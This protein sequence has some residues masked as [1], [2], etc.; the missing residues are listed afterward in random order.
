MNLLRTLSADQ[1]VDALVDG[2]KDNNT[3]AEIAA[4]KAQQDQMVATM[5]GFGEVKEKDVVSLDYANGSTTILLNG[6]ANGFDQHVI[7]EGLFDEVDGSVL[8]RLNR[9]LHVA[10]T[11][12]DD[13]RKHRLARPQLPQQLD[14][15]NVRHPQIGDQAAVADVRGHLEKGC[16]RCMR[17]DGESRGSE[18][19]RK[20]IPYGLLIIDDMYDYVGNHC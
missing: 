3:E 20:G 5:K 19:K 16:G 2:L 6:A 7:A 11:R 1:L 14:A 10:M 15:I 12:N 8:H 13:R 9:H 4:V 18:K 17:A